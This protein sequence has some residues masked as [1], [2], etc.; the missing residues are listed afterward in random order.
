MSVMKKVLHLKKLSF[1]TAIKE[2]CDA[3]QNLGL[4]G[5]GHQGG[6]PGILNAKKDLCDA[7]LKR[8]GQLLDAPGFV[9]SPK[10]RT[11]SG[12]GSG[13]AGWKDFGSS[14][15]AIQYLEQ[16]FTLKL[17][18]D[19]PAASKAKTSHRTES[20]ETGKQKAGKNT[21][22]TAKLLAEIGFKDAAQWEIADNR[23]LRDVGDDPQVWAEIKGHKNALYA[24]CADGV[25]LYIGKTARSIEK[26][27]V[28]YRDPGDTQAT[29]RKCH[30][31]IRK[32]LG[33]H[34][35]VRIMVFPDETSL[36]WGAFGINLAA[37]L[38]DALVEEIKP[39]LNGK[40]N[41]H[42]VTES[43]RV[44]EEAEKAAL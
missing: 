29:N 7:I 44:E 8:G 12:S 1:Y 42:L 31:D 38:E 32:R 36:R 18:A 33:E 37:G 14:K 19:A 9:R 11:H 16:Y 43:E 35:T 27:F 15:S 2:D 17:C 13:Y 26:R 5:E 28:G 41:K 24:F 23:K 6:S 22:G 4:I 20:R 40:G 34:K 30:D 10:G 3:W 21:N 25:V 39:E